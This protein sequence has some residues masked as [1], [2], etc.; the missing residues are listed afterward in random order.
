M[1]DGISLLVTLNTMSKSV[2]VAVAISTS[3]IGFSTLLVVL[4]VLEL[5]LGEGISSGRQPVRAIKITISINKPIF[6]TELL[7]KFLLERNSLFF[8]MESE[9]YIEHVPE[10]AH[11][12]RVLTC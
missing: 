6:F 5:V 12:H 3:I 8:S 11:V 2:V 9:G 10:L 1:T 7:R 4:L